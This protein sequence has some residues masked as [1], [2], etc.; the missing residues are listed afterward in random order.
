MSRIVSRKLRLE[1]ERVD[2]AQLIGNTVAGLQLA[3]AEKGIELAT[4]LDPIPTPTVG[5]TVTVA[6][7]S[8]GGR[9]EITV[10]DTG[11]GI[12]PEIL[13]GIFERFR[14]DSVSTPR[15]PPGQQRVPTGHP[16]PRRRG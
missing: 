11:A 1:M 7:R 12:R 6:L 2:L 3:A 10:T 9:A 14:Q 8:V 5:G 15:R 4:R 13:P 16:G